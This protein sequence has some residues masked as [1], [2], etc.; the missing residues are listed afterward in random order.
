V[1]VRHFAVR[2]FTL[3][4]IQY[5]AVAAS[6]SITP[7]KIDFGVQA[8]NSESQPASVIL[9]N[10]AGQSI[11]L[12]EII[13][14]GIDFIARNDCKTEL[15]PGARCSIQVR[16]KPLIPGDRTGIV[17]IVASDSVNPHFVPL[18]EKGQ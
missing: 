17:E 12:G 6:L 3:L 1:R 10:D 5:S 4:F 7:P 15:P 8:V 11:Q 9:S 13:A 16:F 14:S 18:T 2:T